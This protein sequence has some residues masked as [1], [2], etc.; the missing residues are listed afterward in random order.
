M[1][2]RKIRLGIVGCGHIFKKHLQAIVDNANL[3]EIVGV[4]NHNKEIVLEFPKEWK[5]QT[6]YDHKEMFSKLG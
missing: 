3:F 4:A 2:E 6:F 1:E 5:V